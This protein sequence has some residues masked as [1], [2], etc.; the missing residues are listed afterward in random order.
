MLRRP[1][2]TG[3]LW[4]ATLFIVAGPRP[5][6]CQA[7]PA[8]P[9]PQP[10]L[11]E[12]QWNLIELDGNPVTIHAG[13]TQPYIYL[14]AQGDRLSGSGGCNRFFGSYDVSGGSLQF[15][16]VAQTLMA[17]AGDS[18]AREPALLEALKLTTAYQISGDT[19]QL[20]VDDRVLARFQARKK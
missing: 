2:L 11:T 8:T 1:W 16:S 14:Q 12:T 4:A 19:L 7:S 13:D 9:A 3:V 15:H 20:R 6:Y 5:G 10:A 17:C 18:A